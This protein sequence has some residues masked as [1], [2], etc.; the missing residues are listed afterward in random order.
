MTGGI[1]TRTSTRTRK[2]G[3][4]G[5]EEG[6]PSDRRGRRDAM[7]AATDP[8]APPHSGWNDDLRG[9][10]GGGGRNDNRRRPWFASSHCRIRR[11]SHP[12]RHR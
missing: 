3:G 11:P 12:P 10:G 5:E 1:A 9:V 2:G 7:D 4:G 6:P 8:Y